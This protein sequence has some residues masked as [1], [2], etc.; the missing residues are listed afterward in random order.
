MRHRND[1]VEV[2]NWGRFQHYGHARRPLWIKNY[3]ALLRKPDYI[4]LSAARRGLLHSLWLAY[5][6]RDGRLRRRDLRVATGLPTDSREL[7]ALV[8]A[9][10]IDFVA[11]TPLYLSLNP[12]ETRAREATDQSRKVRKAETWLRNGAAVEVPAS[13]LREVLIDEFDLEDDDL[14]A[15]LIVKAQEFIP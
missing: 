4:D 6:D 9:G 15:E 1:W 11:S 13:H 7:E 12:S 3:T 2:P 5:A 10:F 14:L 8:H